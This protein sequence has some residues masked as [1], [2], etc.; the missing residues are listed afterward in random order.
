MTQVPN[1]H[2]NTTFPSNGGTAYGYLATPPSGSGPGLVVIQ[3]WW[4]LTDHV[5]DVT[6]RFAKQGFV[7]LAPDLYGGRTTHDAEEAARLMREL[8]VDDAAKDLAGAVDFLRTNEAVTSERIGAVGFC[9]GGKFVLVL[10][11][12]Q[13]EKIGAAIPFYGLPDVDS[14]DFSGLRAPVLGHYA[15]K[16]RGIDPAA[17]ERMH[18]KLAEQA[19]TGIRSEIHFYPAEHAFFND[20]NT[21]TYHADSA[22]L[23]W[24]RTL[25]FLRTE[26]S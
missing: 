22:A 13:G 2:Q 1:A 21:A 25:E 24:Q 10:A 3:E 15:T 20:R 16:D 5:A 6:D 18:A 26:L 12:Q 17:V 19:P 23:A 4:G 8:P 9:M 14:T 11:A 7:A